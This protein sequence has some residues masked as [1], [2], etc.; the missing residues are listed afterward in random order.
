MTRVIIC[1]GRT[2]NDH[3]HAYNELDELNRELCITHVIE[4]GALG[5]DRIGRKWAYERNIPYTTVEAEW[6]KFGKRAGYLRN[7]RMRDEFNPDAIIAM[8]GGVGTQ[9]MINLANE[10]NIPVLLIK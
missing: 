5:A 2:Y 3:K 4:G 10:K 1:G 6:N 8:P 9:M 7:K